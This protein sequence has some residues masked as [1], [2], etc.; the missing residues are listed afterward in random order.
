MFLTMCWDSLLSALHQVINSQNLAS[1]LY[2]PTHRNLEK[3]HNLPTVTY[4]ERKWWSQGWIQSSHLSTMP[5]CPSLWDRQ[6]HTL[7]REVLHMESNPF[8]SQNFRT[9]K[10]VGSLNSDQRVRTSMFVHGMPLT[11]QRIANRRLARKWRQSL[12][13]GPRSPSFHMF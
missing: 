4:L 13:K 1:Y 3:W 12:W 10:R 11:R 7:C 6:R 9:H 8:D 5:C 2:R